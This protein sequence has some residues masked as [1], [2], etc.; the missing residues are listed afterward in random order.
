MDKKEQLRIKAASL[1][2]QPGVYIMK[3]KEGRVV[4]V[5]KSK[6]LRNRVS[7]YFQSGSRHDLKTARMVASVFDFE[8]ILTD[9]EIEA[10]ALENKLIKLYAPHYNIRLKDGKSYPYIRLEK[11]KGFFPACR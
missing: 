6:A 7:Q 9:T 10:L 8:Y 2:L 11:E 5:G 3:N 1:P 4:Y